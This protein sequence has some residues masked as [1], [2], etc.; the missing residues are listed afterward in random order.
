LWCEWGLDAVQVGF[1][2]WWGRCCG[3]LVGWGVLWFVVVGGVGGVE[4][5]GFWCACGSFVC[6]GVWRVRVG[7]CGCGLVGCVAGGLGW[8][9][10]WGGVV[11]VWGWWWGGGVCGGCGLVLVVLVVVWGRGWVGVWDGGCGLVVGVV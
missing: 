5:V 3:R 7:L 2:V 6:G 1:W 11:V 8:C 10:G 4:G 9:V